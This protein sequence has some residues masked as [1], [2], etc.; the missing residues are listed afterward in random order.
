[1]AWMALG[2]TL[3]YIPESIIHQVE[4]TRILGEARSNLN[5]LP[6]A[7]Q[8]SANM[9]TLAK[10]LCAV[11]LPGVPYYLD[12]YKEVTNQFNA[13]NGK[14]KQVVSN[15]PP[16]NGSD[17]PFIDVNGDKEMWL[18]LCSRFSP[19]VVRVYAVTGAA[20]NFR[21]ELSS[22]YYGDGDS[23]HTPYPASAMV[24]DHNLV[25]RKYGDPGDNY[26][27]ACLQKPTDTK[28]ADWLTSTQF[29]LTALMPYC[30]ATFMTGGSVL[31][32]PVG[33]PDQLAAYK[34][35]V[36]RWALR[37]A[38]AAGMSVFTYLQTG[39]AQMTVKPYYNECQLLSK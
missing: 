16:F 39:G 18:A 7:G 24:L 33:T 9:L 11:V 12:E 22:L 10:G 28:A 20:P 2:G 15:Y 30:D 14:P 8:V 4:A 25:P 27:P 6:A 37:G 23:T 32:A 5:L 21:V 29:G 1:M 34:D 3:K 19:K 36:D 17:V 38:I 13:D 35:N 31:W 26:Y